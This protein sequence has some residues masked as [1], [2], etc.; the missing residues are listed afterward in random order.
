MPMSYF[1]GGLAS[2][3][4]HYDFVHELS[5]ED[6]TEKVLMLLGMIGVPP[7]VSKPL[8]ENIVAT[9]GTNLAKDEKLIQH[10]HNSTTIHFRKRLTPSHLSNVSAID[11]CFTEEKAW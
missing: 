9:R 1:C 5:K 7:N 6:A 8:V 10:F 4:K 2:S 11:R 3:L